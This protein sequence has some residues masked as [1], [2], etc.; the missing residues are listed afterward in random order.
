MCYVQ[1]PEIGAHQ[2]VGISENISRSGI[3]LTLKEDSSL[4]DSIAVGLSAT[5]E[6]ELPAE[7]SLGPKCI[8]GEGRVVRVTCQDDEIQVAM[9]FRNLQ[10]RNLGSGNALLAIEPTARYLM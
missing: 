2:L 5:V 1:A 8:R 3:L 4:A 10:F 7:H 9:R 6:V